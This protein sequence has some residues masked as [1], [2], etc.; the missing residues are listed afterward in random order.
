[1]APEAIT[2][3]FEQIDLLLAE[4]SPAAEPPS[5]ARL[6]RTL[7]DGYAYALTLESERW[8]LERR[9]AE[10]TTGLQDGDQGPKAEELAVLSDRLSKNGAALAGLRFTLSQLRERATEARASA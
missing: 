5:L 7:T 8:R 1:V 9:M 2:D 6:E 4:P 10:L 3:L